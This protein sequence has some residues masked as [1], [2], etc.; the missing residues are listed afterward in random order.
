MSHLH[1]QLSQIVGI[2][3]INLIQIEEVV[4]SKIRSKVSKQCFGRVLKL[5]LGKI[6]LLDEK[7]RTSGIPLQLVL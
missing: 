5:V 4:V 2:T 1:L 3:S 6:L 7:V